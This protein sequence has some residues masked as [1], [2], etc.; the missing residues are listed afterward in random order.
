VDALCRRHHAHLAITGHNVE[1]PPL[2]DAASAAAAATL[3]LLLLLLILLLPV[4]P[5]LRLLLLLRLASGCWSMLRLLC[6]I[7]QQ[8]YHASMDQHDHAMLAA[9][10]PHDCQIDDDSHLSHYHGQQQQQ[11]QQEKEEEAVAWP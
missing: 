1:A 6:C 8:V 3:L 5:T 10:P 4:R 2:H 7:P 9:M 11:Q